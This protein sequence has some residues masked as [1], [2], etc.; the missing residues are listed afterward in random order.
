VLRAFDVLQVVTNGAS[1]ETNS[2]RNFAAVAISEVSQ[3]RIV[4][5]NDQIKL[6]D[7]V[8]Q[9]LHPHELSGDANE[10]SVVLQLTYGEV[11]FL[12]TGDIGEEAEIELLSMSCLSDIDILK[13]AHHGSRY[14]STQ[15]FLDVV[16]PELAVYSAGVGNRYGH[17]HD[18]TLGRLDASGALT[19]GTD[20]HG[21]IRVSTDGETWSVTDLLGTVLGGDAQADGVDL[22]QI[23]IDRLNSATYDDFRR[24]DLVGA[25]RGTNLVAAQPFSLSI[26]AGAASIES[27]LDAVSQIGETLRERIARHF[28]PELYE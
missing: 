26:C 3:T 1:A 21:T 2:Y 15:S 5:R 25:V 6:S 18:E 9:I 17:P 7:L 10:D 4:H 20:V 16:Q 22:C 11:S 8:L 13:V 27:M 19:L 12:F 24:I 23:C 28:C 14:S